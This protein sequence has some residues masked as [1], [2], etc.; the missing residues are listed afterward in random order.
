MQPIEAR[1]AWVYQSDFPTSAA[2]EAYLRPMAE[3]GLNLI[4]PTPPAGDAGRRYVEAAHR[5]EIEVHPIVSG[6]NC[7]PGRDDLLTRMPGGRAS[8]QGAACPSQPEVRQHNIALILELL[9]EQPE[10]DGIHLD[11]IGFDSDT[12]HGPVQLSDCYCARCRDDFQAKHGADPLELVRDTQARPELWAAWVRFRCEVV[13]A[14]AREIRAAV[15]GASDRL[16]LS[17]T[18]H[19]SDGA[20]DILH[21]PY[22]CSPNFQEWGRW[23]AEGIMDF[24]CPM[25]YSV[26]NAS[27]R[28]LLTTG[29]GAQRKAGGASHAYPGI[30]IPY[31]IDHEQVREQILACR[32]FG[33]PGFSLFH[34]DSPVQG[35]TGWWK[36]MAELCGEKAALPHRKGSKAAS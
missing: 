21:E 19:Q 32:Q 18:A 2:A 9:R 11:W 24:F 13:N 20:P 30:G 6:V 5:L 28:Q 23:M 26:D 35:D 4:F 8:G 36:I 12:Y 14:Y 31:L 7:P 15:K 17:A 10:V 33:F 1:T 16:C 22:V 29:M 34:A 27:F 3:A 25:P